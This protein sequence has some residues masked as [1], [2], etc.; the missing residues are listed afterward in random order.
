M[1]KAF[2]PIVAIVMIAAG[3]VIAACSTDNAHENLNNPT[4]KE[5]DP[6]STDFLL[7]NFEKPKDGFIC[8]VDYKEEEVSYVLVGTTL[9][10]FINT[11]RFNGV[12]MVEQSDILYT[13][14][15][16]LDVIHF[17][18]QTQQ[19]FDMEVFGLTYG[20]CDFVDCE[21]GIAFNIVSPSG[22]NIRIQF[23]HDSIDAQ[24]FLDI[25]AEVDA[26]ENPFLS[27]EDSMPGTKESIKPIIKKIAKKVAKKIPGVA[28]LAIAWDICDEMLEN[29]RTN[30]ETAGKCTKYRALCH[31]DCI[32]C[33][34]AN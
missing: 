11:T 15:D 16:D 32:D 17:S 25:I 21:G 9:K 13:I 4:A 22:N 19:G 18:N 12:E 28:A 7:E 3:V 20:F 2:W 10:E 1:K 31:Y 8:K 6:S 29:D 24:T 23:I 26:I 34:Q 27:E 5:W 33:N 14:E 30:C